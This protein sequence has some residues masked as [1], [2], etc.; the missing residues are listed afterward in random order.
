MHD[1]KIGDK[2]RCVNN[3]CFGLGLLTINKEYEVVRFNKYG[4]V[5]IIADDGSEWG[6]VLE[7]FVLADSNQKPSVVLKYIVVQGKVQD[8]VA[9]VEQHLKQGYKLQGGVSMHQNWFAQAL[10]L[11][12]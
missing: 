4:D 12:D 10:I 9:E 8:M 7:R 6:F 2:V 1:F 3:G 5:V 11:G